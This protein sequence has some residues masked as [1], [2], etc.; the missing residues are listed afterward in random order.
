MYT[1]IFTNKK[2]KLLNQIDRHASYNFLNEKMFLIFILLF[3]FT[4]L[5][6]IFI[7]FCFFTFYIFHLMSY[8][9]NER[10]GRF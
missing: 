7:C 6:L 10:E 8:L 3:F 2:S 9:E 4:L 5:F 1:F